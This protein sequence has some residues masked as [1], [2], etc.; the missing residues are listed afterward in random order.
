MV[1]GDLVNDPIALKYNFPNVVTICFRH[2]TPQIREAMKRFC[3]GKDSL[4]E[5]PRINGRVLSDLSAQLFE[6][7][8]CGV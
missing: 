4:D 7:V 1:G 5:L 3:P 8:T 2:P 6:V